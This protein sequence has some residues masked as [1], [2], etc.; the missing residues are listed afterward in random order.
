MGC[1]GRDP[2]VGIFTTN[3]PISAYHHWCSEV[4]SLSGQGVQQYVISLSVTFG[5]SVVFSGYSGFLH[6]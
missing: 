5:K 3:Y 2:M 1:R 4:E 6:Q